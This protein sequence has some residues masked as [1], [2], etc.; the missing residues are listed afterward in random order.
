MVRLGGSSA[1][2][3]GLLLAIVLVGLPGLR[4]EGAEPLDAEQVARGF[5]SWL[6]DTDD[7]QGSFRQVLLSGAFGT[8]IEERG[9]V[10]V[11][12]PGRMRW[13]YLDPESKVAILNGD[14]TSLYIGEEEQLILGSLDE[15]GS[16][17]P[18]LIAAEQPVLELFEA[19]LVV[20][21]VV[22]GE[23]YRLQLRPRAGAD[24]FE[25]VTV[26]LSPGSFSIESAEVLDAAGNRMLYEFSKLKR[27]KGVPDGLFEF[28]AP[29]G[30]TV[31]GD[32]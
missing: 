22:D 29:E 2:W 25:S 31:L 32:H 6:D 8:G 30:T 15:Q 17:L 28:E 26:T 12:R 18:T 4:A 20:S 24:S 5:Q 19:R 3:G 16:L 27:N 10:W 11:K 21:S 13:D 23:A 7:L 14:R 9:K 1:S